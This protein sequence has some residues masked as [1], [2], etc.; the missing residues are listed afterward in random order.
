MIL[1]FNKKVGCCNVF[2]F[3][4]L[5]KTQRCSRERRAKE[6]NN[7]LTLRESDLQIQTL[8]HI[9]ITC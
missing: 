9:S 6:I 2:F 1:A 7:Y 8:P 5:T 4:C 3:L